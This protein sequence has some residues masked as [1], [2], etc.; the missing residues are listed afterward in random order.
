MT[1]DR[2]RTTDDKAVEVQSEVSGNGTKRDVENTPKCTRL[3][4]ILAR[5][6]SLG[7]QLVGQHRTY[8]IH[9]DWLY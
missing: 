5:Q 7:P 9:M 3:N 2:Q 4:W 1:D 8:Y 6:S